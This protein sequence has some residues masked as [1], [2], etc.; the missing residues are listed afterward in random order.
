MKFNCSCGR[1]SKYHFRSITYI[2]SPVGSQWGR[3]CS[4]YLP[5]SSLSVFIS[6]SRCVFITNMI[7]EFRS[8]GSLLFLISFILIWF[9]R[10][11]ITLILFWYL[12]KQV[13]LLPPSIQDCQ[14]GKI[15][16]N[17]YNFLLFICFLRISGLISFSG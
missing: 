5:V 3:H 7:F 9:N 10:Y 15:L 14:F 1:F 16:K 11:L 13:V 12:M 8:H 4:Y 2:C 6:D 17:G